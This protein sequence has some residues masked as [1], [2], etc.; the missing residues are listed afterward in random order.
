MSYF[1]AYTINK[2]TKTSQNY[3]NENIKISKKNNN[4][5]GPLGLW[6]VRSL[7]DR[8]ASDGQWNN[9]LPLC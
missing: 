6:A 9:G 7:V 8:H 2:K 5:S 3:S 1:L 4:N